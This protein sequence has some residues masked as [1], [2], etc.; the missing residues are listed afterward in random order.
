MLIYCETQ[1]SSVRRYK[2]V[3]EPKGSEAL[4]IR[5]CANNNKAFQQLLGCYSDREKV[6][7][8]FRLSGGKVVGELGCDVPDELVIAA[9][10]LPVRIYADKECSLVEA[11][12]YLEFSFDPVIRAQFEKLLD[13]TYK[14][15]IDYLAISNST[16]VVIRVYLYLREIQREEP[17]KP[18][19]PLEFIDWLFT[20]KL[21]HQTRNEHTI[22]LFWKSLEQWAGRKITDEE[23]NAA[24]QICNEDRA[25]LRKI[26]ALR[27]AKRPRISGTEALVIIGS[28][29]FMDRKEHA[30]LVN[31]VADDACG[32]PEIDGVRVYITGSAQESTDLYELI[33]KAGGVVVG[34]DHDWGDRF[35]DRDYDKSCSPVRAIVD[36]YM[37]RE[38]SSK[39]A[40]VSQ[41]VKALN[42]EADS[43][44]AQAV[45]FYINAYEEA[46]SWDYPSQK[47][48]LESRGISTCAMMKMEYP[49]YRND[50]LESKIKSFIESLKG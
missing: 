45:M 49:V 17:D 7:R 40:F 2:F 34:E 41:R 11:D 10:M 21:I 33:E 31:R 6:S 46:A 42:D 24:A 27:R 3:F 39:K 20:R 1:G 8:R 30:K 25:A 47:K 23:V 22:E 13:G 14:N 18:L 29:F 37:L 28:A 4:S 43:A 15:E 35:Y 50:A 44:G 19:P 38:F 9:G 12:K 48:S 36:R 5:E 26:M 32:W 16:D